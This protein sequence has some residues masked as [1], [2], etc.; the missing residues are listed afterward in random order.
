VIAIPRTV[1]VFLVTEP[2]DF[3][4]SIDGLC[5]VVES[6]LER[7]AL[8]GHVFVFHN[9]SRKSLKVLYWDHGGFCLLYKRLERGRF[10]V[11]N[12]HTSRRETTLSPAEFTALMEGI[13]LSRAR[14]LPRWNPSPAESPV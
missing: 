3:R 2:V 4:K 12:L 8:T 6:H 5:G 14:R 9:K 10:R 11:P 7:D 1:R 13:D